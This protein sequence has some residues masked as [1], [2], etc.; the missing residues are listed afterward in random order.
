MKTWLAIILGIIV[1]GAIVGCLVS[2]NVRKEV[3]VLAKI[4]SDQYDIIIHEQLPDIKLDSIR[5]TPF[6]DNIKIIKFQAHVVPA[7]GLFATPTDHVIKW[8]GTI[9]VIGYSSIP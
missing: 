6:G 1:A 8:L 7:D 9:G 2:W 5:D 3:A 4:N